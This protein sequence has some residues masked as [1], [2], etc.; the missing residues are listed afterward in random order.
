MIRL[1]LCCQFLDSPIHF[2]TATATRMMKMGKKER[3][4][5]LG[6]L[7][8]ENAEALHQ[9]ITTCLELGIG[10]FRINSRFC[11][12]ITHPKIGYACEE[13][14][15]WEETRKRLAEA[16]ERAVDQGFRLTFHPDQ[17]VV[18]NSPNERVVESSMRELIYHGEIAH[19]VGADVINIHA[20]GAYGEKE[21]AFKRLEK[22]IR[23]L[24]EEVITRLTLEN[25]DTRFSPSDLLPLCREMGI[26]LCYDVHHHRCY[27][28]PLSIEKATEEAL[29]T[30]DREPLFH[31]SSPKGGW[32]GKK[33]RSHDDWIQVEDFPECWSKIPSL[34]IEVEAKQ[35]ERSLLSFS[36]ALQER[37]VPI[38]KATRSS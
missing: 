30:W 35:K 32:E 8:A 21:E 24:P 12:L 15:G 27:P 7:V 23:S 16:R 29:Q 38:W 14:E 5:L 11:P 37:G 26:P 36:K 34:T 31:L 10:S 28:D 1:G 17:F 3:L 9:T 2:R 20:G 6:E 4:S 18:L 33:P 25:D 13:L 19:L 22:T